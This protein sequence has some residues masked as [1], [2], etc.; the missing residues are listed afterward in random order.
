MT[1]LSDSKNQLDPVIVSELARAEDLSLLKDDSMRAGVTANLQLL[2]AHH[3]IVERTL[4]E[5]DEPA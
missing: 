5:K 4:A 1:Q 3:D 2:A